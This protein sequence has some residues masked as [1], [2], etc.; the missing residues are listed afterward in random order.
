MQKT[1]TEALKACATFN[2]KG[3]ASASAKLCLLPGIYD[4]KAEVAADVSS[5]AAASAAF[6]KGAKLCSPVN[7]INAGYTCDQVA[8]EI[9]QDGN[10]VGIVGANRVRYADFLNTVQ[11]VGISVTKIVIQNKTASQDIFDQEIEVARTAIGAKGGMDFI[12]LQNY[13]NVNA[14]DRSKIEID[15]SDGPLLLTPEVYMAMNIPAG[16]EFSI[17]FVFEAPAY[18]A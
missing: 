10:F 12:Q 11:R 18:S 3:I 14:Y 8:Q 17:S 4:T 5:Y 13:V 1:L 9:K 16:A 15:L 7:L 6:S 2:I